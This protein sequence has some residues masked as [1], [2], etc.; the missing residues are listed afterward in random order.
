MNE[1]LTQTC[2]FSKNQSSGS[3]T[4]LVNQILFNPD[5]DLTLTAL[6]DTNL[7]RKGLVLSGNPISATANLGKLLSY[8]YITNY[9]DNPVS[10]CIANDARDSELTSCKDRASN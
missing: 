9:S 6:F 8:A 1:I 3:A 10:T 2:T 4:Y 5:T 7:P